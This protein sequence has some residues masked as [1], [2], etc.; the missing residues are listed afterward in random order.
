MSTAQPH[1]RTA[2]SGLAREGAALV[3]SGPLERAAV[4]ALWAAALPLLPG[5]GVLD[6]DAVSRVDSAGLALLAELQ[7][8]AGGGLAVRG[9]PAGLPG[10]RAAYRLDDGLQPA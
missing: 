1:G 5:A 3:F 9:A 10:L 2:A 4:P 7:D 6:L 8:R